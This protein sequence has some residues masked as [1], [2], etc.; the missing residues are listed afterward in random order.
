[1]D[2]RAPDAQRAE[3]VRWVT[4]DGRAIKVREVETALLEILLPAD[5]LFGLPAGTEGPSVAHGW[6]ALLDPLTPGS[7]QIVITIDAQTITTTIVVS[8]GG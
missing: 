1:V 5:N 3:L 2:G 6:V 8:P 4:V 7:H